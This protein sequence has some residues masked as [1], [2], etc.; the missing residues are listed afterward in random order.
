MPNKMGMNIV[1]ASISRCY[2]YDVKFCIRNLLPPIDRQNHDELQRGHI[3]LIK[4][5]ISRHFSFGNASLSMGAYSKMHI[6]FLDELKL[7]RK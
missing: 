7:V 3:I 4:G 5:A 6:L 2:L 1:S